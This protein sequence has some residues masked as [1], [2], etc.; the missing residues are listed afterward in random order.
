VTRNIGAFG[1]NPNNITIFGFSAGGVSVHS[2]LASPM[3]RGLF[4]KA[5]VESGGSRDSV[6]TARP[7]RA[8]NVDP[9][10]PVSAETIGINFAKSMGID[11]I[12]QAALATL[13]SLSA[14]E[15]LRGAPAQ[16]GSNA[17]SYETTPILDGKLITETAETAYKANHQPRVPL[18]LGSN[19]ADTAGNRVRARSK[20]ELFARYGQ[21]SADAK[22]AYDPDGT[23]DLATMVSRANND[24]GQA[25]PARFAANAFAANGSLV[26]LYR[27]SYVQTSMREQLRMGRRMAVRS[28]MCSAHCREAVAVRPRLRIWPSPA[29]RR[30]TGSTSPGPGI[31]TVTSCQP[32]HVTSPARIRSLNSGRMAPRELAPIPGNHVSTSLRR[33]PTPASAPIT[34]NDGGKA[35]FPSRHCSRC[36]C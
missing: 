13:R 14:D 30:A 12:D 2:M 3:A 34:K 4:Q 35:W 20:D 36:W 24:F 15:V 16:P 17:P 23:T 19:S 10:Y 22:A 1:G 9:N 5:I 29:W 32:G 27:F 33:P 28:R 25:E 11:G 21:W 8:D 18:L 26:F 6:L 7:L 31:P